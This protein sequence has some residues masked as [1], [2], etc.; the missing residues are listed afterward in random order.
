VIRLLALLLTCAAV[1]CAPRLPPTPSAAR[2]QD[3]YATAPGDW[4]G[5]GR[6]TLSGFGR[7]ASVGVLMRVRAGV[8]RAALVEDGGL[9]LADLEIGGA[10]VV[11]HRLAADL[12]P[13]QAV[14]VDL[15]AVYARLPEPERAWR[16]GA[17][18]ARTAQDRRSYA[19]DPLLLRRV[20]GAGWPVHVADFVTVAGGLVPQRLVADGP[21]TAEL[22][23]TLSEVI[24]LAPR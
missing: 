3:P 17:L 13:H 15:V 7:R 14:L 18:R 22:R 2:A 9:V 8:A 4:R 11:V 12:R 6:L 5:A 20:D 24:A 19:G 21:F 23:L 10:G 1:G 16:R